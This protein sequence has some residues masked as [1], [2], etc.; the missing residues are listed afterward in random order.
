MY[1]LIYKT[2]FLHHLNF[3]V[4]SWRENLYSDLCVKNISQFIMILMIKR[5]LNVPMDIGFS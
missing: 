3:W 2:L 5:M 4:L 1:D